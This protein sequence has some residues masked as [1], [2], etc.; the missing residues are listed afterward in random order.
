MNVYL[1]SQEKEE[2]D[3]QQHQNASSFPS[4]VIEKFIEPLSHE[5]PFLF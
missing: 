1:S 4:G 2:G 3:A 5:L